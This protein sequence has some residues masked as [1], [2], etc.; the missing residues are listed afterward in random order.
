M[1]HIKSDS[2]IPVSKTD[3]SKSKTDGSKSK[4]KTDGS[5]SKTDI[6]IKTQY[7]KLPGP[8]F[9][10]DQIDLSQFEKNKSD[11]KKQRTLRSGIENVR[12][13]VEKIKETFS[14]VP[15]KNKKSTL[16]K[17]RKKKQPPKEDNKTLDSKPKKV[18][19]IVEFITVNELASLMN[20]SSTQ[21]ITTCMS[22]G[23]MVTMNQRLDAEILPLVADEFGYSI[24][25]V[26]ED[27]DKVMKEE[28][29]PKES[30]HSRAPIITVMGHVDHGK[31]SFLDY[32]RN[33]K[34][35]ES[36]GITQHI[37]AYSV[38]L[39]NGRCLTFLDTPGHEAFT[40]MRARGTKI[41]DIVIIV[42][43]SD[44][45]VMPQ[46]KEAINHAKVAGVPLIFAL[47]KI[48]KPTANP[49][50][51]R[52][53]LANINILVE[54]W[55]G[56]YQSQEISAKTG[57]GIEQLLDKVWLEAELLGLKAN[58]N[59]MASGTI[60]ESTL[61]KGRGYMTTILVQS[62]TI[63]LGDYILAG[64]FH[65][66]VKA[67]FDERG[68]SIK[69]A[70]PS[71][72]VSILG[73]NGGPT[74]GDKFKVFSNDKEAKQLALKKQ[75]LQ[76]EHNLRIHKH[77]TLT[78]VNVAGK[79]IKIILKGD[80]DGS[81]EAI[82]N[83]LKNLSKKE[84]LVNIIHKG[85]GQ[86]TESDVLLASASHSIIIGFNVRT[87]PNARK[88]A[89]REQIEIRT[90]SIIYDVIREISNVIEG[91]YSPKLQEQICGT[92]EIRNIFNIP[93]IVGTVAGCMVIN[94]K[95]FRPA[96]IKLIRDGIVI[97]HGEL[98]SLKRFKEDV[99]EVSKGYECGLQIKNYN[100]LKIGDYIEVYEDKSL[101]KK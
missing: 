49:D 87:T 25:F 62:G 59:K 45:E 23:V 1:V 81:V 101:P 7:K 74:A 93:K 12:Q 50:K 76:R 84:V 86:I 77:V 24:D 5:K 30:L 8:V 22:L 70:G 95:I 33:T 38:E 55:G 88:I 79:E 75:Q 47:N 3:G 72:P 43:A 69:N 42:I 2:L 27:I 52:E 15:V 54:E 18:L 40:S 90:Y 17:Y 66:K 67:L 57:E 51:I 64:I 99:K 9:T 71:K 63:K 58:P 83:A 20:V 85:V 44:E 80:V 11:K 48:D 53:Q 56:Q 100:A 60:I 89:E 78:N 46:T 35:C 31:T 14:K 37:G 65:G 16:L 61:D 98:A 21:L 26:G 32:V 34:S 94:G 4:S 13:R 68:N 10:G 96:K 39:K 41:T 82:M 6:S 19:Q 97:F 28:E 92:A 73:L 29:D 91:M 36:G